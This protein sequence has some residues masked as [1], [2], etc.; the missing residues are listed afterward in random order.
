L[1]VFLHLHSELIT[2]NK[3]DNLKN[4]PARE[5]RKAFPAL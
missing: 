3:T 4:D 1:K 2:G 5:V